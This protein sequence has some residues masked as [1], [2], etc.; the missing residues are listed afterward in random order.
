MRSR[1]V[2]LWLPGWLRHEL[3]R[4]RQS[5]GVTSVL[6]SVVLLIVVTL[7]SFAVLYRRVSAPLRIC[8][9]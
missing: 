1:N 4:P 6:P 3:R 5:T 9:S 2:H 7:A 8:G